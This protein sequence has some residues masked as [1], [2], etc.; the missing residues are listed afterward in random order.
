MPHPNKPL[1]IVRRSVQQSAAQLR[2]LFQTET[3][4]R[5]RRTF[6]YESLEDRRV[7]TAVGFEP[8]VEPG[9]PVAA[10]VSIETFVAES[11]TAQ[12]TTEIRN[13]VVSVNG[14]EQALDAQHA[15]LQLQAG[16]TLRIVE[17]G[18]YS[19]ATDGVF[20]TESYVNKLSDA[21]SG[22]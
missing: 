22:S 13:L 11:D 6:G 1:N 12:Q 10:Y 19:D 17:V 4:P 9:P 20:A 7:L 21:N 15:H 5:P 14:I 3:Q 18:I 16:D 2:T 8:I